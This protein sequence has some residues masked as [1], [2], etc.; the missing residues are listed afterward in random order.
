ME[1]ARFTC[2]EDGFPNAS[3]PLRSQKEESK[4]CLHP[5]SP[6]TSTPCAKHLEIQGDLILGPLTNL[7]MGETPQGRFALKRDANAKEDAEPRPATN[8]F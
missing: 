2:L 3:L 7:E 6:L 4:I 5:S 1:I 8:L